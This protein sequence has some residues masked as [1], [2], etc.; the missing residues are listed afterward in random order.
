VRLGEPLD[1][2]FQNRSHVRVLR[3]L[4][5]LPRGIDASIREIARRA[6]V[7]HPTASAALESLRTQGVVLNRVTMLT[8]EYRLNESHVLFPILDELFPFEGALSRVLLDY[9]TGEIRT[10]APWVR[11]AFVFGSA[12]RDDMRPDSDLD[13]AL[14]TTPGK[15]RKLTSIMED[16]GE[17]TSVRF[18]NRIQAVIGT[19]PI[20][21]LAARGRSRFRVWREI[22]KNGIR[23]WPAADES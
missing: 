22:A 6:G 2:L 1:D 3:A 21:V 7:T 17:E 8:S 5:A 19:E 18:G 9:L 20:E 15:A 23:I 13:V 16:L 10:R 4:V 14:V 11:D 12:T